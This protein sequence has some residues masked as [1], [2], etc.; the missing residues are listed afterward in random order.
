MFKTYKIVC[1][2][3]VIIDISINRAKIILVTS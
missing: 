3:C 1:L 2:Y